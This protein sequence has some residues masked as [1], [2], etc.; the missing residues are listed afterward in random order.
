MDHANSLD[1]VLVELSVSQFYASRY[2]TNINSDRNAITLARLNNMEKELKLTSL[3]YQTCVSI[4]FVGYILG[5]VP[6]NMMLTRI[7]P[8]YWMSFAMMAWAVVSTLTGIAKDYKGLLLT[9]FFLGI[10]GES[11]HLMSEQH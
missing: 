7:R 6:S 2:S 3:Q 1:H 9:R 8:S 10:T 5:Q 4:L 11:S